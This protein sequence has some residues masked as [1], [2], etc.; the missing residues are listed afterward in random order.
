MPPQDGQPP[1]V[2]KAVGLEHGENTVMEIRQEV[3][4]VPLGLDVWSPTLTDDI[5]RY[6]PFV[7]KWMTFGQPEEIRLRPGEGVILR[8]TGMLLA[9][10]LHNHVQ[11]TVPLCLRPGSENLPGFLAYVRA[12]Q[13]HDGQKDASKTGTLGGSKGAGSKPEVKEP[14]VI[15]ISSDEEEEDSVRAERASRAARGKKR[16]RSDVDVE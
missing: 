1:T 14:R 6:D 5:Q 15:V 4:C 11:E 9:H 2:L 10:G 13:P 16:A 3:I 8:K 7:E 12:A